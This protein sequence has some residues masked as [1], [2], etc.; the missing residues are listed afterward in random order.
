MLNS[1][2]LTKY[3]LLILNLD[4]YYDFAKTNYGDMTVYY[5]K[6]ND[7][8]YIYELFLWDKKNF[9]EVKLWGSKMK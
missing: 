6:K 9:F 3:V 7:S 1:F 8:N 4:K 2:L 5:N